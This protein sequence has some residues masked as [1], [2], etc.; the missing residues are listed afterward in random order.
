MKHFKNLDTSGPQYTKKKLSEE[1]Y[2]PILIILFFLIAMYPLVKCINNYIASD[3][4]KITKKKLEK[5]FFKSYFDSTSARSALSLHSSADGIKRVTPKAKTKSMV[6]SKLKRSLLNRK[7]TISMVSQK[8]VSERNSTDDNKTAAT[9]K[10]LKL[11][12]H[13]K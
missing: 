7:N 8:I 4:K 5:K 1:F 12:I 11:S 2:I 10:K 9:S 3:R 6:K 13:N